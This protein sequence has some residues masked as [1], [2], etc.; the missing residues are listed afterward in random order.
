MSR[1]SEAQDAPTNVRVGVI[2]RVIRSGMRA[3]L[4]GLLITSTGAYAVQAPGQPGPAPAAVGPELS[5]PPAPYL[6]AEESAPALSL[7]AAEPLPTRPPTNPLP[8]LPPANIQG[9]MQVKTEVPP[10]PV[11]A[12]LPAQPRYPLDLSVALRLASVENPEIATVRTEVLSA[13]AVQQGARALLLPTL[14]VGTN[15][16]GHTGNLQRS[17]GRILSLSEQSLYVGGGARTLAAESL[18]FP[19]VNIASPLADAWFEPLAA[20]REVTRA[21]FDARATANSVLGEVA[22]LYLDLIKAEADVAALQLATSQ[23][24]EVARITTEFAKA[25]EG[26]QADADRAQVDWRFR[27]AEVQRAMGEVAVASARLAR[28]LNLDPSVELVARCGPL[29]PIVLIDPSSDITDLT[30][31]AIRRRP[32]LIARSAEIAAAQVRLR[33]ELTR[34]LIPTL[35]IGFSGGG[36]GGGSNLKPPLVGHF[37]GRTDFDVRL[38]WTLLNF[39]AGNLG[40]QRERRAQVGAAIAER[41]VVLNQV[42]REVAEALAI[43][44]ARIRQIEQARQQL[45]AGEAGF[46]E[47]LDR[48]RDN[49]GRPIEVLDNLDLLVQGRLAL[50]RAITEY[51]QSQFRLYVA[52]G[53]P[54]PLGPQS[55]GPVP[56]PPLTTP[57][58]APFSSGPMTEC[59]PWLQDLHTRR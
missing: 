12:V 17:S 56:P 59:P 32:E 42:R 20:R 27:Q 37:G 39:G 4:V 1:S 18:A 44:E 10:V 40:L 26:R 31:I 11:P 30:T 34:P 6:P 25:G 57:L 22:V 21:Q 33:Q 14:N 9:A 51:N 29:A 43:S 45:S 3:S 35:W 58:H 50:I 13:L 5:T 16:H 7:P 15:Y 19:A 47:D 38:V 41:S 54:P 48:A 23:T 49:L 53:S 36:F 24:A 8:P 2:P 55:T 28:Q 52:L 46:E